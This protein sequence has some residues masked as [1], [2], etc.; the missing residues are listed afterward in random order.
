MEVSGESRSL[1]SARLLLTS[2]IA[3]ARVTLSSSLSSPC[4]CPAFPFVSKC[5]IVHLHSSFSV[6]F[7]LTL[8]VGLLCAVDFVS[9]CFSVF[10]SVFLSFLLCCLSVP[11]LVTHFQHILTACWCGVVLLFSAFFLPFCRIL[12]CD[13]SLPFCLSLVCHHSS[14]L[15]ASLFWD[16]PPNA[17]STCASNAA[18]LFTGSLLLTS[19]TPHI[20]LL[21]FGVFCSLS[22]QLSKLLPPPPTPSRPLL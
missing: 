14:H 13:V 18:L 2:S 10:L 7:C 16:F 8:W 22:E 9:F 19:T 17:L 12:V 6:L 3:L 4:F 11:G 5:S 15:S 20:A 21:H 1:S